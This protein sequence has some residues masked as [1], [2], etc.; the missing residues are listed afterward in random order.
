MGVHN[1]KDQEILINTLNNCFTQSTL[2]ENEFSA[3]A[4]C[5]DEFDCVICME[6]QVIIVDDYY[7]YFLLF[8]IFLN[9]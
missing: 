5:L 1:R 6:V 2:P 7:S 4:P 8:I 3:S 9:N